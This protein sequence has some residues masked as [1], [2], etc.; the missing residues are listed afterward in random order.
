MTLAKTEDIDRVDDIESYEVHFG[1]PD[2]RRIRESLGMTQSVFASSFGISIATL[3]NLEQGR[4]EPDASMRSYL[5]VIK[6]IPDMVIGALDED[7]KT[8]KV[9]I[10]TH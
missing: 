10:V 1:A 4:S 2:I 7:R 9:E 3:R 6:N 8:R 5:T